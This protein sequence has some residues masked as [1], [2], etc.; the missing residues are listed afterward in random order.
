MSNMLSKDS[1]SR[2][3]LVTERVPR[4]KDRRDNFP[5]GAAAPYQC[6]IRYRKKRLPLLQQSYMIFR[7]F[8]IMGKLGQSS[9]RE[10]K[11]KKHQGNQSY[12]TEGYP[13]LDSS[14][15]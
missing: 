6:Q 10:R 11:K 13:M 9:Y 7:T 1:D 15:W 5:V 12:W 3:H 2:S 8:S 4:E 14:C